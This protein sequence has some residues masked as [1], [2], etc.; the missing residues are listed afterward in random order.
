LPASCWASASAASW[1]ARQ[2]AW[3]SMPS[4]ACGGAVPGAQQPAPAGTPGAPVGPGSTRHPAARGAAAHLAHRLLHGQQR[5]AAALAP[6][7][8]RQPPGGQGAVVAQEGVARLCAAQRQAARHV[9]QRPQRG[10]HQRLALR[11]AAAAAE[12]ARWGGAG[13]AA[14]G[15]WRALLAPQP[16][17]AGRGRAAAGS[18]DKYL[19]A[20]SLRGGQCALGV[21]RADGKLVWHVLRALGVAAQG[22]GRAWG[23]R[24]GTGRWGGGGG[25]RVAGCWAGHGPRRRVPRRLVRAAPAAHVAAQGRLRV[26]GGDLGAATAAECARSL[27]QPQRGS[28]G[29]R[30]A[31]LGVR[32]VGVQ[33]SLGGRQV[34]RLRCEV[35]AITV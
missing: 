18:G 26:L 12:A 2:S 14:G 10:V 1:R 27:Q 24:S 4:S 25:W 32:P 33:A 22:G 29:A 13:Q 23:G 30:G 6:Q 31:P 35:R 11:A 5:R 20:G 16:M 7:R 3:P 8:R 15:G 19:E 28:C 9:A 21:Q 34:A 17:Q